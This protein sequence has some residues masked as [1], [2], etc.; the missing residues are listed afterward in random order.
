MRA[1][2]G[3]PRGCGTARRGG[4]S[5]TER[6]ARV[7]RKVR[8]TSERREEEEKRE[9]ESQEGRS[10]TSERVVWGWEWRQR[11]P[12]RWDEGRAARGGTGSCPSARR[13]ARRRRERA[14]GGSIHPSAVFFSPCVARTTARRGGSR[15]RAGLVARSLARSCQLQ[16]PA[17]SLLR[18]EEAAISLTEENVLRCRRIFSSSL[19]SPPPFLSF[20]LA[21]FIR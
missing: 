14:A 2:K 20:S 15:R 11:R 16:F 7:E 4:W 10:E 21:R 6:A 8:T 12:W 13:G 3:S 9:G 19:S 5:R 17:I 1:T 18:A